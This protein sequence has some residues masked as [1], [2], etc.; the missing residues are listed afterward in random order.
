MEYYLKEQASKS[1]KPAKETPP[2]PSE[3]VD[4]A[5][6]PA[7]SNSYADIA[8]NGAL[9][10]FDNLPLLL[11]R[12]EFNTDSKWKPPYSVKSFKSFQNIKLFPVAVLPDFFIF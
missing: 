8:K 9:L 10:S 12:S 2:K 5:G 6:K 4:T 1:S 3:N 7:T 11:H